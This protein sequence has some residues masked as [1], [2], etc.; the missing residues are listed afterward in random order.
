MNRIDV[1]FNSQGVHCAAW[2]YR[3]DGPGPHPCVILANGFGAIREMRL[4]AYAERFAQAGL[5][6]LIF[7]YR[8]FGAS[9]GEP[10]QLLDIKQQL[11]DWAAA[12]SYVRG[13]DDIDPERIALWGTSFSGG[14]VIETSSVNCVGRHPTMS[15]LSEHQAHWLRL[16]IPV[17]KRGITLSCPQRSVGRTA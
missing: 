1:A 15:S 4:P 3:P 14:H 16:P 17:P 2:L 5:A 10:R 6:V 12:I 8:H 7:D 9:E 11:A 13:L